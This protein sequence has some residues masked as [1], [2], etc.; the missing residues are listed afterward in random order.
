MI[1]VDTNTIKALF[2]NEL[3]VLLP[4]RFRQLR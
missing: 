3:R 2:P 1:C 4:L